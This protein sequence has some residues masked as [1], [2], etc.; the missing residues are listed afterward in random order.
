MRKG[1]TGVPLAQL[2]G[3]RDS[4]HGAYPSALSLSLDKAGMAVHVLLKLLLACLSSLSSSTV[5]KLSPCGVNIHKPSPV[6]FGSH[7]LFAKVADSHWTPHT[8]LSELVTATLQSWHL[9][10]GRTKK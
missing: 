4:S 9:V 10:C 3:P 2:P 5:T 6:L 1:I 7:G 8:Y